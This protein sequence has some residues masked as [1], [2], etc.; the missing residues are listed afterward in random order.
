MLLEVVHV[1]MYSTRHTPSL[2]R[3][4]RGD[5]RA[6]SGYR[7]YLIGWDVLATPSWGPT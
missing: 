2:W 1:D 4:D 6:R 7:R 5:Y 3:A